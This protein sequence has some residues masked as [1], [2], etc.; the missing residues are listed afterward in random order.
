MPGAVSITMIS[1]SQAESRTEPMTSHACRTV[2]IR[3]RLAARIRMK[4][5]LCRRGSQPR[6][7]QRQ[8]GLEL[9]LRAY[10]SGVTP[11]R[12]SALER[13]KS[14]S[15]K[16]DRCACARKEN[17]EVHG[18]TR[19]AYPT[20][21]GCYSNG[22]DLG[23]TRLGASEDDPVP[24]QSSQS[25][26][27]VDHCAT[28]TTSR[29][30]MPASAK[31][32]SCGTFWPFVRHEI[33]RPVR[34]GRFTM[35]PW[36]VRLIE[37][38]DNKPRGRQGGEPLHDVSLHAAGKRGG[39]A[40][41]S[42][43]RL[44]CIDEALELGQVLIAALAAAYGVDQDDVLV[45]VLLHARRHFLRRQRDLQRNAHDSCIGAKLLDRADSESVR[46][47]QCDF[48]ALLQVRIERRAWQGWWF[49]PHRWGQR[50]LSPDDL[51]CVGGAA[52]PCIFAGKCGGHLQWIV[53]GHK[54][55][56]YAASQIFVHA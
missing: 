25:L 48:L 56:E 51:R 33:A 32:I 50:L 9:R 11:R 13:P 20:L 12:T 35:Q 40:E 10:S 3:H 27:L 7:R 43:G 44:R 42:V 49:C 38:G 55:G 1:P 39:N 19:L 29:A 41:I 30:M 23:R 52:K 21:A 14:A 46:S 47:D 54:I 22:V 16:P 45:A 36:S 18:Q 4:A 17:R 6:R 24:N 2:N 31:S 34:S 53:Y 28:P 37:F 5:A 26:G 15:I 8:R